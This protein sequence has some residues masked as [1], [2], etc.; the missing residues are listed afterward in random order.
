MNMIPPYAEDYNFKDLEK[1]KDKQAAIRQ[2][3]V[4]LQMKMTSTCSSM[5][6]LEGKYK[7]QKSIDLTQKEKDLVAADEDIA[8][9]LQIKN[10]LL[11]PS[12]FTGEC[13]TNDIHN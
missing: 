10:V 3:L 7:K 9:I 12:P 4:K 8:N 1:L 2:R 13:S 6:K 5:K 11:I